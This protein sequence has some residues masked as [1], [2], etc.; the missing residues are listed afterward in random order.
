MY[1][2]KNLNV[3]RI[4]IINDF[5]H[6]RVIYIMKVFCCFS[7]LL[8]IISCSDFLSSK[9]PE[10]ASPAPV[11]LS[12][13]QNIAVFSM[14]LSWTASD[15]AENFS[16]YKIY[17]DTV[18]GVD[19]NSV[20]AGLITYKERNGLK[21][22]DLKHNTTYF[23]RVFVFN[24]DSYI[25]SNEISATT[26]KCTCG[27]FDNIHENGM[28]LI[29]SGCFID[30][31]GYTAIITKPFFMDT[32]EVTCEQWNT[33]MGD[34]LDTTKKPV[35]NITFYQAIIYCN[36]LSKLGG[37]DTCYS[38]E[39]LES[40]Y[41]ANLVCDF[42][43]NGYR[44]PSEDEWEYAYRAGTAT[45]FYWGMNCNRQDT[46]SPPC[47]EVDSLQINKHAWWLGNG[48]A[49]GVKEAAMKLPN[50]F[51]LYDMAGNV[52]EFVWDYTSGDRFHN[53]IDYTGPSTG[54]S[55]RIK[56]GSF[57]SAAD[58][59]RAGYQ[60]YCHPFSKNP[61]LGFRVAANSTE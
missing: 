54:Y 36:N 52:Q 55:H 15:S 37:R 28:V 60:N 25:G 10:P 44:L 50:G 13:A 38:Y 3:L 61:T 17:Y 34:S 32:T 49:G 39:S 9:S 18:S 48:D 41:S 40:S 53:R 11:I 4:N 31:S 45:D 22:Q 46:S 5:S 8:L 27:N 7:F 47:S 35:N 1:L 56:G 21:L 26:V 29:P 57:G 30:D 42:S 24:S 33:V 12:P 23:V 59:L 43:K 6:V 51:G 58:E 16:A 20:L 19:T 2:R 14:E